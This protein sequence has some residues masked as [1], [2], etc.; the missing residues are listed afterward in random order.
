MMRAVFDALGEWMELRQ[1]GAV[2]ARFRGRLLPCDLTGE[3]TGKAPT[4]P[5]LAP[6]ATFRLLAAGNAL[7][8]ENRGQELVWNGRRFVILRAEPVYAGGVL[9]YWSALVLEKGAADA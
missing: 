9:R 7:Q 4:A 6:Q 1:D 2:R 3:D 5:G 8:K